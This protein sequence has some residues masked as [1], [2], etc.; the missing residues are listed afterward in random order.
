MQESAG[1]AYQG[2]T[3]GDLNFTLMATQ[4]T[5]EEERI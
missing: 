1:N 3:L 5:Y 2:L 4:Y